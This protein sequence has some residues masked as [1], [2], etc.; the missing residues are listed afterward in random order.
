MKMFIARVLPLTLT[1]AVLAMPA[2]AAASA[3]I[4]IVN[5]DG[6]NEGFNDPTPAAPV[7]G[8]PGTTKGQQRLIAFQFA[9]DLWGAALD[10]NIDIQILAAF[11]PLGA[12]VLGSAGSR[13]SDA[14]FPK[15]PRFPGGNVNT[16]Y[17]IALADKRAGLDLLVVE[18][19]DDPNPA[20]RLTA[21]EPEIVAQFSSDFDFYLGLDNNHGPKND[22]VVVLLHELGHGLGFSS[23]LSRTTGNTPSNFTDPYLDNTLD[24][25]TNTPFP[26]LLA[27]TGAVRL[28]A[29][30]KVD[31]IVWTGDNVAAAV[32]TTLL[33]G[34]PQLDAPTLPSIDGSRYGTAAF[35]AP[36]PPT[37][38]TGTVVVAND[39][40]AAPATPTTPAGTPTDGCEP[41]PPASAA[42]IAGKIALVDRGLCGFI[43]KVKNAQDAGAIA[44]LV[45]DNVADNPPAGLGGVDPT[46]TIS[47]VRV[48]L[49]TGNAIKAAAAP[50]TV[51]IGVNA[52]RR[53]GTDLADRP[54]LYA[55]TPIA[56]GSTLNHW[57][58]IAFRNLLME[59]AINP[60]LTHNLIAP[61]DTT[62]A[63]MHDMGW[64]T[65]ADL[66]GKED[67]TVI[68][69]GCDTRVEND[70]I[71]NGALLA[72]Q[73]RVWFAQ[74]EATTRN[75]RAFE[76]CV[77]RIAKAAHKADILT[78]K[79]SSHLRN[80]AKDRDKDKGKDKKGTH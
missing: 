29:I 80:C 9:A 76:D 72:D 50:V 60:D 65:D 54:Q 30:Q 57:D 79:Q 70:F 36:V 52:A 26:A 43:V 77:E 8:N 74:C 28:A 62:L 3:N 23:F 21:A 24:A 10:S 47:S 7:G 5:A 14:N 41:F 71:G 15:A 17:H 51:T 27:S 75:G 58:P 35:G 78:G 61:F 25:S 39:G 2:P 16:N 12:N 22:L 13:F 20:N 19:Q 53:A 31:Q 73:A 55:S 46:I 68:V 32:P 4:T 69:D 6:P 45:A 64:F 44:V 34:R 67:R 18:T 63:E 66:N 56:P 42:A 11:N 38:I 33:F 37:G 49:A 59:P 1:A 40:I 48:L